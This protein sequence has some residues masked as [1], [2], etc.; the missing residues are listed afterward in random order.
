VAPRQAVAPRR[1]RPSADKAQVAANA[2]KPA[3]AALPP[4]APAA[5]PE[6]AG[7]DWLAP[8]HYGRVLAENVGNIVAASDARVMEGMAT[9]GDVMT[10]ITKKIHFEID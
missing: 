1:D 5:T 6:P 2:V 9:V 10:T 4:V 7:I 3:Q 8:L